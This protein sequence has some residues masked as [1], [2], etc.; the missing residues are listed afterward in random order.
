MTGRLEQRS[1]ENEAGENRSKVE[2]TA[3][4]IGPALRFATVEV[5]RNE[6]RQPATVGAPDS[7]SDE[8]S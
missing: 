7:D 4:D 2:I 6:R 8:P 5:S 3:E 1:W